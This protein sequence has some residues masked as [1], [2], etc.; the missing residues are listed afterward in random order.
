MQVV[1]VNAQTALLRTPLNLQFPDGSGLALPAWP[2]PLDALAG[3]LTAGGWSWADKW[4][5]LRASIQWQLQGFRCP[6]HRTVT[7]LC[8]TLTPTV[9]STLIDPLCVSALNTP[10]HRASGQ[11]FLTVLRDSLLGGQGSSNLLLPTT[12]LASLFPQAAAHWLQTQGAQV[13]LGTRVE[14]LGCIPPPTGKTPCT[15]QINGEPFDSVIWATSSS[16]AA[17]ALADTAQAATQSIAIGLAS[18]ASTAQALQFEAIATVYAWA[19]N[20]H[21]RQPMLSLHS[22]AATTSTPAAPA[23]YVFDRGQLGGPKGLLAFVVSASND[24]RETLQTQVLAQA[25]TQLGLHLQAV[26]TVVEK[27]ATFACTP[28]LV[29]PPMHIA[30][31]LLACGDYIEGPYPATLESA[32]RSGWAAG[33]AVQ[34]G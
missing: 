26:Q 28:A 24:D 30:P 15:W 23:Q 13:R 4:S 5:L 34:P 20:A 22:A 29:R 32:V 9:V 33:C 17:A 27:R 10:A 21:L 31:G 7:E 1:G 16:N 14:A 25:R 2:A 3:M 6:A 8:T 19:P 11:V 18:W 12:D